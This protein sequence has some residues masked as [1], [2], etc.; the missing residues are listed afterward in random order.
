[1][2]PKPKKSW[3]RPISG[4][5]PADQPEMWRSHYKTVFKA[6]EQPY[7]GPL[8]DDIKVNPEEAP[9][10]SVLEITDAI[11]CI[12]TDKSYKRHHHWQKLT[13]PMEHSAVKCLQKVLNSWRKSTLDGTSQFWDLFDTDLSPIPKKGKKNLSDVKSWRPISVGTS[14]NWIL[15]KIFLRRLEPFLETEDAQFGCKKAIQY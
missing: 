14:E 6:D 8:L 5:K 9:E 12:N 13:N 11:S 2:F 4:C 10:F 3:S 7:S 15:E 1:M